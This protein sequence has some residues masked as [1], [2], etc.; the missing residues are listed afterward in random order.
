MKTKNLVFT[1]ILMEL[2]S[3]VRT[4]VFRKY[5]TYHKLCASLPSMS[6]FNSKLQIHPENKLILKPKVLFVLGGP[7]AGKGI[8]L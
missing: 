8:I 2:V 3:A 4:M 1:L 5:T 7:G 6:E